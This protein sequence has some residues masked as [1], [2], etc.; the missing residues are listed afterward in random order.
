MKL[1]FAFVLIQEILLHFVLSDV[2]GKFFEKNKVL[3]STWQPTLTSKSAK[4][5]KVTLK[6]S[7]KLL[8]Q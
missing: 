6:F 8:E 4:Y 2:F 1:I 7:H 5:V 3:Q